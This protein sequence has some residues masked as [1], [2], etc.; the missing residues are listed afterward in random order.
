MVDQSRK[1]ESDTFCNDLQD[2][3][4]SD[5]LDS[6]DKIYS[7]CK[8]ITIIKGKLEEDSIDNSDRSISLVITDSDDISDTSNSK[9]GSISSNVTIALNNLNYPTDCQV[10]VP[11]PTTQSN[12]MTENITNDEPTL[13]RSTT[14]N[15]FIV[16]GNSVVQSGCIS[17]PLTNTTSVITSVT[18]GTRKDKKNVD[19]ILF[20]LDEIDGFKVQEICLEDNNSSRVVQDPSKRRRSTSVSCIKNSTELS[21]LSS[22]LENTKAVSGCTARRVSNTLSHIGVIDISHRS[23]RGSTETQSDS[24]Q[25]CTKKSRQSRMKFQLAKERKA[26]TTLGKLYS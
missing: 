25:P 10:S 7:Q 23:N 9:N 6:K 20:S 2:S 18:S 17:L 3:V 11:L 16:D 22:V 19:D 5:D 15:P 14:S 1:A 12:I 24:P 4:N 26:S 8:S 13:V 21:N